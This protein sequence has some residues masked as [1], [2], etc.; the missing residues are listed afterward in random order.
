ML[1]LHNLISLLIT[2]KLSQLLDDK[3]ASK[4]TEKIFGVYDDVKASYKA[5]KR[6][7]GDDKSKEKD[8]KKP[9]IK[10][11]EIKNDKPPLDNSLS[12]DKVFIFFLFF[13]I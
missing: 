7:H 11:D 3:K 13:L 4:L 10:D 12:A 2:D 8:V 5:K 6:S 9:R 1:L